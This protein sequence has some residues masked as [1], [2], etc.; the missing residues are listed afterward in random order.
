[1]WVDPNR[2]YPSRRPH[3][4]PAWRAGRPTIGFR[5]RL[6]AAISAAT[7]IEVIIEGLLIRRLLSDPGLDGVAAVLLDE[8]HERSPES[9]LALALC[10]DLQRVLRPDLRLLPTSATMENTRVA[11]LLG[12]PTGGGVI[13]SAGRMFPVTVTHAARDIA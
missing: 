2:C 1:M 10:L 3:G 9:D 6:D 11:T 4:L 13:E 7:R 8:V 5:T 12:A